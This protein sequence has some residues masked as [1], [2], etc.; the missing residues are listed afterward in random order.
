MK[1]TRKQL[2][3]ALT[4]LNN[5]YGRGDIVAIDETTNTVHVK[6]QYGSAKY[7]YRLDGSTVYYRGH[8]ARVEVEHPERISLS[9]HE[10]KTVMLP[11]QKQGLQQTATGYG[12]KLTT[13]KMVKYNGRWQRVYCMCYSNSG[14]CYILVKGKKII[15]DD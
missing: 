14:T 6:L 10:V 8:Q 2:E 5:L 13:S 11:W 15:V 1:V 7:G 9:D 3:D 12:G 4:R